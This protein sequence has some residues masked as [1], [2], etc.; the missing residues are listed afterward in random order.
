MTD[1][2]IRTWCKSSYSGQEN[3][4]LELLTPPR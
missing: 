3:T 2:V 1:L 4:C